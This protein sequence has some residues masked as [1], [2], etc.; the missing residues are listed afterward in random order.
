MVA[1]CPQSA[2]SGHPGFGDAERARRRN[3]WL[4]AGHAPR[5]HRTI[6]LWPPNP[7]R[8]PPDS[9]GRPRAAALMASRPR[10]PQ[11]SS[12][13][14]S[15]CYMLSKTLFSGLVERTLGDRLLMWENEVRPDP[16][17]LL[18]P[19]GELT[20]WAMRACRRRAD[21]LGHAGVS[22]ATATGPASGR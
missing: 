8:P 19:G 10:R 20:D 6:K 22:T 12:V 18:V 21:P 5:L 14:A 2:E 15:F 1:R 9:H 4:L 16:G 17:P 3:L 7:C 11:C 13:G